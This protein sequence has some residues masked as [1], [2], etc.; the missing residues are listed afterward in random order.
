MGFGKSLGKAFKKIGKA[1]K[2]VAAVAAPIVGAYVGGPIGASIGG[3]IGGIAS[4]GG[5]KGAVL[6]AGLSYA[7]AN[8]LT[9]A[10][11]SSVGGIFSTATKGLDV[12]GKVA[13]VFQVIKAAN[14]TTGEV[15]YIGVGDTIPSGFTVDGSQAPITV[16]S[17]NYENNLGAAQ[18]LNAQAVQSAALQ[19]NAQASSNSNSQL[20]M[21]GGLGLM[22]YFAMKG[23]K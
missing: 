8:I 15:R 4:G 7:G 10:S 20:L 2:K 3:A 17:P 9:G 19:Q 16:Q 21:L 22:A 12:A 23:K 18:P 11:G 1:V 13:N 5:L 6:G 14:S